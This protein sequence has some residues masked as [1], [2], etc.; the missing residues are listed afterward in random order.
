MGVL[1]ALAV[2]GPLVVGQTAGRPTDGT[3]GALAGLNVALADVGGPE[4]RRLPGL[5]AAAAL[6]AC[7]I[8]LGTLVADPAWL[9]AL[10][11][12]AVVP[13]L[14]LAGAIIPWGPPLSLV[15]S[16]MFLIGA[17]LPDGSAVDRLVAAL[18]GGGWAL[19]VAA[20]LGALR[21]R[22][23]GS[24]VRPAPRG[25]RASHAL[26]FGIATAAA[27]ALAAGLGLERGYWLGITV[28]FVL[29]PSLDPTLEF[30]AHRIAGTLVGAG[31]G[32]LIIDYVRDDWALIAIVVILLGAA[33]ALL[34]FH[35]GLAVAAVTGGV[36]ALLDYGHPGD[37]DLV[38]ERIAN[39]LL[40][41]AI[42]ILALILWPRRSP[43]APAASAP[44]G[45]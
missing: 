44:L 16:I 1:T 12:L 11:V 17:G 45:V 25:L 39:T 28:A 13:L 43:P 21:V 35:Y 8:A 5:A 7:A 31:A 29:H 20:T 38:D 42:A 37:L 15:T 41:A 27:L 4:R 24:P 19:V 9:T 2:L 22:P 32:V 33:G 18:A 10:A 23:A 14:S 40:G 3:I 26:R 36:L 34:S 6:N 30:T